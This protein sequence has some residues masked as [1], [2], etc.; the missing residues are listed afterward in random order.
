MDFNDDYSYF[1]KVGVRDWG[2]AAHWKFRQLAPKA[3]K[4]EEDE[5]TIHAQHMYACVSV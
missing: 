2:G 3:H 1:N 4:D 5:V